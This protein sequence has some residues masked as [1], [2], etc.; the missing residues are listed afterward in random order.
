M[1]QKQMNW[2]DARYLLAVARWVS[3]GVRRRPC[4]GKNCLHLN[5][6]QHRV[7]TV[8]LAR[9]QGYVIDQRRG[10]LIEYF[11]RAEA[12]IEVAGSIFESLGRSARKL[13]VALE[14]FALK[15]LTPNLRI[16]LRYPDLN[17]EIVLKLPG[18]RCPVVRPISP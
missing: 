18:S 10:R 8:L 16:L 3:W 15:V 4:P 12:E 1:G 13:D 17:V 9:Q 5:Q 6:P 11:K 7:G 14:G 2:E